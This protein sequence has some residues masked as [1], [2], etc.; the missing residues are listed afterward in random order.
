MTH[1][2]PLHSTMYPKP[3]YY[4]KKKRNRKSNFILHIND[5][6]YENAFQFK[7]RAFL[8]IRIQITHILYM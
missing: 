4:V 7:N 6:C 1:F 3:V 5:Y 8:K 2:L